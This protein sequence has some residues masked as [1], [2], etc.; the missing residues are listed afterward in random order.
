MYIGFRFFG[1]IGLL[2][3]PLAAVLIIN[4]LPDNIAARLGFNQEKNEKTKKN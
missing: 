1:L 3:S 4:A 2:L